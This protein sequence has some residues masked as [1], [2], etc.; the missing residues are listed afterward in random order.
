MF[1]ERHPQSISREG[2]DTLGLSI[3]KAKKVTK[4]V[5][6][7]DMIYFLRRRDFYHYKTD[8]EME[9]EFSRRY[10]YTLLLI[11][12]YFLVLLGLTGTISDCFKGTEQQQQYVYFEAFLCEMYYK[13]IDKD[14]IWPAES[15]ERGIFEDPSQDETAVN[16]V[17]PFHFCEGSWGSKHMVDE[18][19]SNY[20]AQQKREEK[21]RD[22]EY[23]TGE[24]RTVSII[25]CKRMDGTIWSYRVI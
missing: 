8:K 7:K 3:R 20:F 24:K 5:I 16:R 2:D 11:K 19:L 13:G 12:S 22:S 21:E 15:R 18:V 4:G 9:L 17:L 6:A 23:A 25:Q 10:S 1:G 14:N